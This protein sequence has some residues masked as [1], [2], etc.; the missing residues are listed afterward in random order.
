[1]Y[2][3]HY[4]DKRSGPF[5]SVT[6]IPLEQGNLILDAWN[7]IITNDVPKVYVCAS[8]GFQNVD[9]LI[10]NSIWLNN[11]VVKNNIDTKL[12]PTEYEGNEYYYDTMLA[13]CEDARNTKLTPYLEKMGNCELVLLGGDH[14][15]YEQRPEECGDIVL[16]FINGLDVD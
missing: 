16:E 10:E 6:A 2:L 8:W 14:A 3:Y 7:G 11:Q 1:M 13:Q 12:R 5:R 9:E 15:I 4:Y